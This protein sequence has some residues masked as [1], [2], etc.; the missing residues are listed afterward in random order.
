[1]MNTT[2]GYRLQPLQLVVLRRAAVVLLLLIALAFGSP[3][4]CGPIH[5]AARDGDLA[6]V[7]SLLNEHPDLVSSKDEKYGQTPLHIAAFNDRKDVAELLLASKADVNAQA[8]NGTTPLHLAA[9]KGNKDIVELLLNNK[10]DVNAVDKDGWSPL[11]SALTYGQKDIEDMLRQNGGQN[12]PAPKQAAQAPPAD[13]TPKE[14][15]KDGRFISYDNGTVLDTKSNLMWSA[16]DNGSAVS[17]PGAKTYAGNYRGGG[18][19]DWRLP[20]LA[21]L[22]GLYDKDKSRKTFC[23]SAVDE[24]GAAADEIHVTD[25]MHLTC[26]RLWTS[27][28]RSEKPSS[29]ALFDFH[30]GKDVSR[31][32]AQDFTDTASRVLVVRESKKEAGAAAAGAPTPNTA[33]TPAPN[34]AGAPTP[35]TAGTPTPK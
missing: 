25:F 22:S 28:E 12:L 20:T 30:S 8:N 15:G 27:Q 7:K 26:T 2:H 33:G 9:G 13:K 21:E 16:S 17:W 35:N 23:A 3:G 4:F 29:V 11:H 6:K 14:T 34:A 10:A 32:G 5:D 31:S 18:Y 24:F 19:S 1:M